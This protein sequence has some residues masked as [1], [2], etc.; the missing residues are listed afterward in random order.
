[1]VDSPLIQP[2]VVVRGL[3]GQQAAALTNFVGCC[4]LALA[5]FSLLLSAL[6]DLTGPSAGPLACTTY[7]IPWLTEWKKSVLKDSGAQAKITRKIY[8]T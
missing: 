6:N 2:V 1:M 4:L 5:Y 8:D 3:K 7:S